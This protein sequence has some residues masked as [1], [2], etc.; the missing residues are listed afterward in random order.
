MAAR[1]STRFDFT[2]SR[3]YR[4]ESRDFAGSADPLNAFERIECISVMLRVRANDHSL[5]ALVAHVVGLREDS[6]QGSDSAPMRACKRLFV[7]AQGGLIVAPL[8]T[9]EFYLSAGRGFSQR[10]FARR[11]SSGGC[12]RGGRTAHR[13]PRRREIGVRQQLAAGC[14]STMALFSFGRPVRDEL[15]IRMPGRI[16]RDRPVGGADSKLMSLS[17]CGVAGTLRQ[18][19]GGSCA[20][21]DTVRRR[22]G[23]RRA[24]TCRTRQFA[25]G[26]F[27]AYVKDLGAWGGGCNTATR[28]LSPVLDGAVR[29]YR[30]WRVERRIFTTVQGGGSSR[31]GSTTSQTEGQ[32]RGVLYVDRL[33]GGAARGAADIHNSSVGAISAR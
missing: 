7:P 11:R 8:A 12:R 14:R 18:L 33:P 24:D 19:F 9:T 3:E 28:C 17:G 16:P 6:I 10:R 20:I 27:A 21:Q 26:S 31:S 32:R 13:A 25:T 15:T 1:V 22:Y 29:G 2:T 30:L 4:P 5:A 23:T